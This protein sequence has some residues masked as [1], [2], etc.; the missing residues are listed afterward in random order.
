MDNRK[1]QMYYLVEACL[2]SGQSQKEF[3]SSQDIKYATFNY[4]VCKYRQDKK[5]AST[6]D[7]IPLLPTSQLNRPISIKYPNNIQVELSGDVPAAFIKQ[8]IELY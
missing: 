2:A 5:A 1:E 4:W 7:F 3:A 8:L 6:T